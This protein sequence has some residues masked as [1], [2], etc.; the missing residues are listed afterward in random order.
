MLNARL[1]VAGIAGI[2]LFA[3]EPGA[4]V[5]FGD[6]S[7]GVS[8]QGGGQRTPTT[9]PKT[10]TTAGTRP[11]AQAPV[12][13]T[14]VSTAAATPDVTGLR[15]WIELSTGQGAPQ[16]VAANR[17][18]HSGERIRLHVES[19]IDGELVIL[20]SQDGGKFERLF[21]N[22]DG[23]SGRVEKF[24]D[25]S[26]PSKEGW[27]RFDNQPGDIRVMMMLQ[28]DTP[29][30]APAAAPRN[31]GAPAPVQLARASRED[32]DQVMQRMRGQLDRQNSSKALVVENDTASAEPAHYVVVDTR[33]AANVDRG[34]VAAEMRLVHK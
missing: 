11:P 14:P 26:F 9:A 6:R 12:P 25:S 23:V 34:V 17:V 28:A 18:F 29:A 32:M 2:S 30:P 24:K 16:R 20:Q 8:I 4:K 1:I 7:S 5:L 19:N 13:L 27:F 22:R 3:Q 10:R 33:R 21:P 15:Y 31:S